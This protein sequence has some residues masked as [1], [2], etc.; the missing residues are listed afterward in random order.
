MKT[1]TLTKRPVKRKPR[2]PK[3]AISPMSAEAAA[4]S[5]VVAIPAEPVTVADVNGAD[6]LPWDSRPILPAAEVHPPLVEEVVNAYRAKEAADIA[7]EPPKLVV[8]TRWQRVTAA[9]RWFLNSRITIS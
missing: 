7:V 6:R 4:K 1:K 2:G 5:P 8:L 9:V 3:A